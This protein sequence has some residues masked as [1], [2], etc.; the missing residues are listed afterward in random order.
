MSHSDGMVTWHYCKCTSEN[1][2]WQWKY[3]TCFIDSYLLKAVTNSLR[4]T[5]SVPGSRKVLTSSL[6]NARIPG[7]PWSV[8]YTNTWSLG[9]LP[10]QREQ[11]CKQTPQWIQ[12]DNYGLFSSPFDHFSFGFSCITLQ[13]CQELLWGHILQET[14][15][16]KSQTLL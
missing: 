11:R 7:A 1:R 16:Q 14:P 5:Q 10:R 12:Q 2:K 3:M 15:N 13:H 4:D 6:G 9:P 8:K